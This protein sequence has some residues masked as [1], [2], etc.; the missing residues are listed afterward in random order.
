MSFRSHVDGEQGWLQRT[1]V[2]LTMFKP[3]EVV[4]VLVILANLY[5][6][7]LD[8]P[9]F[10][11]TATDEDKLF[12]ARWNGIFL[13]VFTIELVIRACAVAGRL[14]HWQLFEAAI[15]ITSWVIMLFPGLAVFNSAV[16]CF[17]VLR[18]LILFDDIEGMHALCEAAL[19]SIPSLLNVGGLCSVIVGMMAVIGVQLFEGTLHHRCAHAHTGADSGAFCG[20]AGATCADGFECRRFEGNGDHFHFDSVPAAMVPLVSTFLLDGW[21]ETMNVFMRASS[22]QT[23]IYFVSLAVVG[24]FFVLQLFPSVVSSPCLRSCCCCCSPRRWPV[25]RP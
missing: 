25:A 11:S 17:R 3:F 18:V 6:I 24:G 16:R 15:V 2:S 14:S 5:T 19:W 23:S 12:L 9:K 22:W 1:A 21:A 7:A 20:G 4:V 10:H 13:S 8:S